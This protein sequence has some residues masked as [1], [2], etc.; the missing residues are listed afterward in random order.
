MVEEGI[1]L[2]RALLQPLEAAGAWPTLCTLYSTLAVLLFFN[3]RY[4]EHLAVAERAL[5]LARSLGDDALVANA[6][7]A[8]AGGLL[9]LGRG[10]EAL[11]GFAMARALA[12][13]A[14]DLPCLT[15]ALTNMATIYM[16]GG[17]LE[18][19][20]RHAERAIEVAMPR[21]DP[22]HIALTRLKRAIIFLFNGAWGQAHEDMEWIVGLSDQ[23]GTSWGF[24][25][26]WLVLGTLHLLEGNWDAGVRYL[27]ESIAI[28]TRAGDLEVQR[29]AHSRLAEIDILSGQAA[30]AH[31]RILPLLDRSGLEE[32][33]VTVLLPRLAWAYLELGDTIQ[34]A[35][36]IE[37]ALK[38]AGRQQHRIA[39]ADGL[40]IQAMIATRQ[41]QWPAAMRVLDEGLTLTRSMPYPYAEARLLEAYGALHMRRGEPEPAR[42]QM[43]A[44]RAV[45]E[46]LGA[47]R[48][49]DRV[50][51]SLMMA[52]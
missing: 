8:R 19:A 31:D 41:E 39:L 16:Y 40:W 32:V 52:Q 29:W 9:M 1:A 7:S 21:G 22:M 25:Y 3:A 36:T 34:A 2:V 5:E 4:E 35:T 18:E 50:A 10:A 51:E 47:R 26:P 44:A 37:Q 11:E 28:G 24:A 23:L 13:S 15:M 30:E 27:E 42:Q 48:D 17:A 12:E 20:L 43:K 49:A 33:D 38:R 45:F 46:R 6:E 14:G